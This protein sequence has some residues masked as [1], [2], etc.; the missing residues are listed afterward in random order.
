MSI[1]TLKI[2]FLIKN[3]FFVNI[4]IELTVMVFTKWVASRVTPK[5]LLK[6]KLNPKPIVAVNNI[7]N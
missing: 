7:I 3:I 4:F 5:L 1:I 2:G 6:F